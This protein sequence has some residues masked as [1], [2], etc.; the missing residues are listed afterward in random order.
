MYIKLKG[1]YRPFF[2]IFFVNNTRK[3][4]I[5][6]LGNEIKVPIEGSLSLLALGAVGLKA[7]REKK[8]QEGIEHS[9]NN[10]STNEKKE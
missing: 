10:S 2:K 3:K 4:I 8:K 5:D 7:W 1:R 9:F 6:K